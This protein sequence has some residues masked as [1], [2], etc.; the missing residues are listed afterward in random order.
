MVRSDELRQNTAKF[1]ADY[2][3]TVSDPLPDFIPLKSRV[4]IKKRSQWFWFFVI[5][6]VQVLIVAPPVI[7]GSLHWKKLHGSRETNPFILCPFSLFIMGG[8]SVFFSKWLAKWDEIRSYE[9][10]AAQRRRDTIGA[11]DRCTTLV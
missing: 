6:G 1:L 3:Q 5:Q 9:N 10:I 11:H 8:I 4:Q 7:W 2:L